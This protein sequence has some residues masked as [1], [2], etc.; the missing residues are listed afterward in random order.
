MKDVE[1]DEGQEDDSGI[2]DLAREA[3]GPHHQRRTTSSHGLKKGASDIHIEPMERGLR[4]RYA[5]TGVLREEMMLPKKVQLPLIS[6]V[7]IISKLDITE[8]GFPRTAGSRSNSAASPSISCLHRADE[9]SERRS[10]QDPRQDEHD[11]GPR[12]AHLPHARSELVRDMIKK[13]YAYLRHGPDGVWK[14]HD[15]LHSLAEINDIGVNISTVEDPVEYDLE[16]VNQVQVNSDIGLDFARVLR[17][18]PQAGPG[19]HPRRQTLTRRPRR[20]PW[21]RR[22]QATRFHDTPCERR[23]KHL[24]ASVRNGHRTIFS[25]PPS[26]ASSP[27]VSSQDLR[28]VQESLPV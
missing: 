24:H 18:F 10:V 26:S 16:G 15:A 22:S 13:P 12:Q 21:R 23:S 27:S 5:S 4:V 11:N 20:S 28:Q 19:H 9:C 2:T 25:P 7:K 14:E 6:R 1:F 3:E 17:A 8:S